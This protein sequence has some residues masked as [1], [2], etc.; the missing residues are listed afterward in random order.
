M[1]EL[2]HRSGRLV[3]VAWGGDVNIG[4]RFHYGINDVDGRNALAALQPLV[5]ADIGIINLECVVATSGV[6]CVDKGERASY[7]FR[8]RP[9][10]LDVLVRGGVDLVATANNHSGDYGPDALV[11]QAEWLEAAGLGYAGSGRT[12]E[13]AFRPVFRRAGALDIALFALDATQASF[14]AGETTPGTAWL[15]PARPQDWHDL[16]APRIAAA[17]AQADVILVAIHW[18]R[19]NVHQPD[20]LEIAGGHALIDAGADAVLGSSAHVLQG[21]EVYKGRP[22][23]HD[24]GDLLFDALRRTDRDGGLFSLD[25]DHRGVHCVRFSP[26]ELGFCAAAVPDRAL[27][28]EM[29]HRFAAKCAALGTRLEVHEDGTGQVDLAPPE[30]DVRQ[31]EGPAEAANPVRQTPAPLDQPRA[32]WL[33]DEVP[34]DALLP[35]PLRIGPMELLGVRTSPERLDRVG[36][37]AVESWWRLVEPADR[38][39]RI[40]FRAVPDKRGAIGDWGLSCDH[41]PCDW[42]WP[43][44]RWQVGQVYRDFYTLRPSDVRDWQDVTLT[45]SVGLVCGKERI[46]RQMLPRQVRFQLSPKAGYAVFR[47]HPPRYQVPAPDRI[48]P[49]PEIL[50]T[51]EQ[52]VEITGGKWLVPPPETWFVRSVTHKSRQMDNWYMPAPRLLAVI[53]Q[54]MAMKHEL[55]DFTAGKFWDA[56]DRLS[57]LQDRIS[58]AIVARP[59]EGLRPDLPLLLVPDP[60]HALIQLGAAARNRLAGHVVAITGSAG[61][62]SQGLMLMSALGRDRKVLGNSSLNYNSRVGI[63]HLLAN[64]PASTDVVVVEAAVSAINAPRFQNIRLVRPD[65]AIVTNVGPSHMRSPD[66]GVEHVARRKANIIEGM[67]PGGTLLLNSEIACREIFMERAAECG[68]KVMTFGEGDNADIRLLGYDQATGQVR[69]V[70]PDGSGLEYRLGAPGRHMALN[71]LACL[72]V[73]MLL[74]GDLATVLDGLAAF[75]PAGGR[76]AV[77]QV[78]FEGMD[79]T[80]ID[81][82]YN[83][84]PISMRAALET[85]SA[86]DVK[87]RRVLVLGD[88]AELGPHAARYHR[89]LAAQVLAARAGKV[90]LCGPLMADLWEELKRSTDDGIDA[91]HYSGVDALLPDIGNQLESGDTVLIKASN[92]VGLHRVVDR[93]TE[94]GRPG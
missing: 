94:N 46:A 69:A 81:E 35:E 84:N 7:Y 53:D 51:A 91:T 57:G 33:A 36:L 16:M 73:R 6:A 78:A 22:I 85:F 76:G 44:T 79:L 24:A 63:L 61:K 74:G 13:E 26:L 11:E 43:L 17:R 15:D 4:R 40:D 92:S 93:L 49:T 5:D 38:D 77:R 62:T 12:L 89:E 30:R 27:A 25:M 68:V 87:G 21:I 29:T 37:I 52:L 56:H 59:V 71:S 47:A 66:E 48:S 23:L 10:M 65:I 34:Q 70:L 86:L 28:R 72:G 88:M 39:W 1:V 45:L 67:V 64:A 8:A 3:T 60:L 75:R 58:G 54:K 82:A 55:S 9:E 90:L 19:N 20:A 50:W 2:A 42:M 14:A 83:A 41:D 80:I 32:E 31:S 18:G